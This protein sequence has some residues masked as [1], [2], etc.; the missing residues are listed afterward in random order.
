MHEIRPLDIQALLQVAVDRGASDIHL[1]VGRPPIIR[2]DGALDVLPGFAPLGTLE[3]EDL[4]D[5]IGGFSRSRLAAFDL[6]GEFDGAYQ[7]R[8]LPRF[9]V[10][11]VRQR[12]ETSLA[13]RV[14]P[15]EIPDL[16]SLRLPPG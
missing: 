2:F 7:P 14:I 8:G 12:S 9:R 6:S 1:K 3:L 5:A 13:F 4:V 10:N 11:A 16:Q 15:R